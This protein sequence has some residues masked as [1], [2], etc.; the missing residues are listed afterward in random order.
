MKNR[1][2]R[3]LLLFS[4]ML[5]SQGGRADDSQRSFFTFDS[6][7]GLADNSAQTLRCTRTGRMV[8]CTIGHVNF[9]DGTSFT[10]IDPAGSDIMELPGYNGH[11]HLYFDKHHHLWLKDKRQVTCVNLRMETFI[12]NVPAEL[13]QMG[14]KGSV[15]DLFGDHDNHMWFRQGN[16]LFSPEYGKTF[17][18]DERAELL[19]VDV[20]DSTLMMQFYADGR[21][22]VFDMNSLRHL[23]DSACDDPAAGRSDYSRSAVVCHHEGVYYLIRNGRKGA[24]LLSYRPEQ[25][26]W[27]LLLNTPY[28]LNNITPHDGLLYVASAQGYWTH[29]LTTHQQEHYATVQVGTGRQLQT[30]VNDI[31]FDRQGGMWMGTERRGLLY[32]RPYA[33]PFRTLAIGTPEA[34]ALLETIDQQQK[35]RAQQLPRH[36]N[37]VMRDSRGWTWTG[38]YSGLLLMKGDTLTFTRRNGLVNEMVHSIVEDNNRNIWVAT[39]NGISKLRVSEGSIAEIVNYDR[40]DNLPAESFVNDRMAKLADGTIV[41][42][43][44][45]HVV[46]FHPEHFHTTEMR[47]MV[48]YPKLSRLLIN[49]HEVEPGVEYEGHVIIDRAIT[50]IQE[51]SVNYDQNSLSLTFTGLNYWRPIQ[52]FYRVRVSGIADEWRVYSYANSR[53]LVD[54]RGM[55]HLPL[56]NLAPG[57]YIIELQASMTPDNWSDTPFIWSVKV[58]QPWWRSTG[59]YVLLM[60]I[61]LL[62]IGANILMMSR[63]TRLHL[64]RNNEEAD[65]L[66]RILNYV[67]RCREMQHDVL[68]PNSQNRTDSTDDDREFVAMMLKLVPYVSERQGKYIGIGELAKTAGVDIGRLY[69]LMSANLYKSPLRTVLALR[70]AE[71]AEMLRT[72][73]VSCDEIANQCG[74]VSPN[75]FIASFYRQYRQ[76][77]A[78]YR[79]TMPR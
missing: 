79:K 62:L 6:S 13:A 32:A 76:T 77:P 20:H 21:V 41:M 55:L 23:F 46:A 60:A 73:T 43:S 69:D 66:R 49:G 14:V 51:L 52:T 53:G 10:H 75:F 72:T 8:I 28:S 45:D 31:C 18:V 65:M 11:Y 29:D 36:V 59:V 7:Y 1:L 27:K 24:L 9:Y 71:A 34:A 47:D 40:N 26:E 44:I 16:Q 33:S 61:L 57:Q 22:A 48:L 67:E 4:V 54:R 37:C 35:G 12:R 2:L 39:S 5:A 56:S 38:T 3:L 50:R 70:V 19:D 15:D 68:M 58:N 74:F 64:Q 30:D 78:D 25:N 63:N 42:Q 17:P